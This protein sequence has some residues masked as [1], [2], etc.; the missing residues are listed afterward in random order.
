MVGK[1]RRSVTGKNLSTL[2]L[3]FNLEPWT[4]SAA[5]FKRVYTGYLVPD[6]VRWR[7]PLL[8]RLLTQRSEMAVCE[9]EV[10]A[11]TD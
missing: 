2:A 8:K 4:K 9:E 3:E 6:V 7:L 5:C 10:Q 11:V 1:D